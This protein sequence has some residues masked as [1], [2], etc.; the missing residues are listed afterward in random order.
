MPKTTTLTQTNAEGYYMPSG[1]D[2]DIYASLTP[3]QQNQTISA[4]FEID[5]SDHIFINEPQGRYALYEFYGCNN[6]TVNNP[7]DLI[8]GKGYF[9]TIVFNNTNS[10]AW[11]NGNKV[12][13]GV[14]KYG[15][16]CSVVFLRNRGYTGGVFGDFVTYRAGESGVKTYQGEVAGVSA[17]CYELT[18][19]NVHSYQAVYDSIDYTSDYGTEVERVADFT[20]AEY[21]W[22]Q[23][24]TKHRFFNVNCYGGK[25][26]FWGDGQYNSF[27]SI[28]ATDCQ[29]SGIKSKGGKQDWTNV[30]VK[31]CNLANAVV[32]EHQITLEGDDLLRDITVIVTANSGVTQGT[33]LWAPLSYVSGWSSNL[34]EVAIT[35]E[36]IKGVIPEFGNFTFG[37][38]SASNNS[39]TVAFNPRLKM[40]ANPIGSIVATVTG[41]TSGDEYGNTDLNCA[42]AGVQKHGV[43]AVGTNGGVGV[44]AV[45]TAINTAALANSEIAF[46]Q[47][48]ASIRYMIKLADGTIKD[49]LLIA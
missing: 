43:R 48:G 27:T 24:P 7:H 2:T 10:T 47:S 29:H 13:G 8:G 40:L 39:I 46:Y 20:L 4:R 23:L 18:F 5:T 17:R 3:E 34:I 38:V 37:E 36:Y 14:V 41:G 33:G 31:N 35:K 45:A 21:G 30:V 25:G 9:G 16:F 49:G 19:S 11:G 32:G 28:S 6:V 15:S 22:H 1:N 44:L 12:V 26:G 42:I